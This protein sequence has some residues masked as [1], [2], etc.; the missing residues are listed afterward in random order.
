LK[1]EKR[2]RYEYLVIAMLSV[3]FLFVF[4][5]CG[6]TLSYKELN[7][8]GNMTVE[9]VKAKEIALDTGEDVIG[10][11]MDIKIVDNNILV[12]D[13]IYSK[14]CF[15]FD[16]KGKLLFKLGI[17]G[18]GPG[19]VAIINAACISGDKI[20]IVGTRRL[21]IYDKN[22]GHEIKTSKKPF[23]SICNGVFPAADGTIFALSYNRYNKNRNTIYHLDQNGELIHSFSEAEDV[24][25]VFD[26]YVPQSSLFV[27]DGVMYQCFNYKYDILMYDHNGRLL[28]TIKLDSP[29]YT[30]PNMRKARHVKRR[31][32]KE[33]RSTFTQF[34]GIYKHPQGFI[35][36]LTNW[37]TVKKSQILLEF[38]SDDFNRIGS[39]EFN[40]SEDLV[41]YQDNRL[42][43]LALDNE[44]QK[45]E[46]WD[47]IFKSA[48]AKQNKNFL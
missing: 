5:G 31:E 24:P 30:K 35:A 4:A 20:F 18:E 38:W 16:E 15:Y 8:L 32:E 40:K 39:C 25:K 13:P 48:D 1:K 19:E 33:F 14:K 6:D 28:D 7:K 12:V 46:F 2:F 43:T 27:D 11:A 10:F 21:N 9:I 42:V 17:H 22:T 34:T 41:H 37:K 23:R 26:T 29:L 3:C 36:I 45:I 44:E 47:V